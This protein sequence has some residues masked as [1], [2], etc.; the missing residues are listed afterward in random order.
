VETLNI[1]ARSEDPRARALS[2]FAPFSF[3]LDGTLFASREGFIIALMLEDRSFER[4]K[5]IVLAGFEAKKMAKFAKR[6]FIWWERQRFKFR[7][8][9]HVALIERGIR[10]CFV[11]NPQLM[12]LL[13]ETEGLTLIH[14]LGRPES[15]KT[16]LPAVEFCAILTSIREERLQELKF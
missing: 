14:D 7:G 15:S 13:L 4:F 1:S 8:P 3:C 9:E 12:K 10:A 11:Q 5:T 6:E 2:N 16:S